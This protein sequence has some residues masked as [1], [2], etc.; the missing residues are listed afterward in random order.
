[1]KL[2]KSILNDTFLMEADVGDDKLARIKNIIMQHTSQTS[3]F[4]DTLLRVAAFSNGISRPNPDKP[5]EINVIP[6]LN[7][8]ARVGAVVKRPNGTYKRTDALSRIISQQVNNKVDRAL[9]GDTKADG[10]L[11]TT[12]TKNMGYMGAD[13]DAGN[14]LDNAPRSYK[15]GGK[16]SG[17]AKELVIKTIK[18]KDPEWA[19][20]DDN[21]KGMVDKLAQLSNPTYSFK[22]LKKLL[23]LQSKKKGYV[24]F[25][26]FVETLFKDERYVEALMDLQNIGV[27]S[28]SKINNAAMDNI[29]SVINFMGKDS[30]EGLTAFDK[31]NA[32]L[33]KFMENS[34]KHTGLVHRA[35]N[36]VVLNPK[37]KPTI[38]VINNRLTD[39]QL[40]SILATD[41]KELGNS[42]IKKTIKFLA[43]S[44]K[45]DSADALKAAI[46]EKVRNRENYNSDEN[47]EAKATGR[48]DYFKSNF[49][50]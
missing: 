46:A 38:E 14:K 10:R 4:N 48:M 24:S 44:L 29:R 9:D 34:V 33:P 6:V 2:L 1:M 7:A 12:Q 11:Q 21:V 39:E 45:V 50:I 43:N 32:M 40:S 31:T 13:V 17:A 36:N 19:N 47:Q 16:Y 8:L 18:D 22:V 42:P 26:N 5:N 37:F 41:T 35:I 15:Q 23:L 27:V 25:V 3:S 49:N 20:L 30:V 28:D